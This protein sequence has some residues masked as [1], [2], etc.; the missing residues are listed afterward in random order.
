MNYSPANFDVFPSQQPPPWGVSPRAGGN[1]S[2]AG[3]TVNITIPP[4]QNIPF[5][6]QPFI[7]IPAGSP[8]TINLETFGGPLPA[9]SVPGP[10]ETGP[11]RTGPIESPSGDIGGISIG[12]GGI[13]GVG[14]MR[15]GGDVN[16]A[17][18]VHVGGATTVTTLVT[19][20]VQ[21]GDT[22]TIAGPTTVLGPTHNHGD[23]HNHTRV[24]N[25]GDTIIDSGI[26]VTRGPTRISGTT[27]L[28]GIPLI[29]Q[30]AR[31]VTN[32]ELQGTSLKMTVVNLK[33]LGQISAGTK[34]TVFTIQTETQDVYTD[35]DAETCELTGEQSFTYVSGLS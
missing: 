30:T 8:F 11:I 10:V 20:S 24:I 16:V 34:E 33:F 15:L 12:G 29:W 1:S 31:V 28:N 5:T 2:F 32:V 26:T 18:D 13:E 27:I 3:N 6:P 35:F 9:L 25:Y 14:G 21:A 23:T 4:W 22:V 19:Q 17:G 7:D